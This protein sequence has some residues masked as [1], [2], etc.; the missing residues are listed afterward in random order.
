MRRR[1]EARIISNEGGYVGGVLG[2]AVSRGKACVAVGRVD[3]AADCG[4]EGSDHVVLSGKAY[5][6]NLKKL[7]DFQTSCHPRT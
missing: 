5:K 6:R 4:V 2:T 7:A 1:G 3:E